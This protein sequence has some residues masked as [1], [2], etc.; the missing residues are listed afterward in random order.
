MQE[1]A[2]LYRAIYDAC[3]KAADEMGTEW[4]EMS[5]FG[6]WKNLTEEVPLKKAA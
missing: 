2:E 4:R 3:L 5:W 6:Q 1:R